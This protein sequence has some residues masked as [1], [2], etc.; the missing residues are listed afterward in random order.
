MKH[1]ISADEK[2]YAN[3]KSASGKQTSF[4]ITDFIN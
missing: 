4:S 3:H 1:K 2:K